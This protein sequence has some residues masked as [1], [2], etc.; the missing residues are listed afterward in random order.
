MKPQRSVAHMKSLGKIAARLPALIV[1]VLLY[2]DCANSNRGGT[3]GTNGGKF[4]AVIADSSPFYRYGPQQDNGPDKRLPKDTLMTVIGSLFGY[5]KVKLTTGEQGFV[6]SADIR[7]APAA[8]VSAATAKPTPAL[9]N[10]P[11]PKFPSAESTP[12]IE[13]TPIPNSSPSDN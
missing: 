5:S 1:M 6:A 7:A 13:P 12:D 9:R 10:Y 4:D 8:L 3:A 2:C 11:E